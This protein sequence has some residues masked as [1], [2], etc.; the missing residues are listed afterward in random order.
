L[1]LYVFG[2][3]TVLWLLGLWQRRALPQL[4]LVCGLTV[5]LVLAHRAFPKTDTTRVNPWPMIHSIWEPR[6]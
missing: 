3:V 5:M 1:P 6:R 4:V 2:L